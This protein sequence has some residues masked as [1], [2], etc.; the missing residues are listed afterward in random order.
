MVNLITL[1]V[2]FA[3]ECKFYP[4]YISTYLT[5]FLVTGTPFLQLPFMFTQ[6]RPNNKVNRFRSH[7]LYV[8]GEGAIMAV[9]SMFMGGLALGILDWSYWCTS[10]PGEHI[11][12]GYCYK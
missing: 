1:R 6:T 5:D 8:S 4:P 3:W 11:S 7:L 10:S 2:V 12:Y 9:N